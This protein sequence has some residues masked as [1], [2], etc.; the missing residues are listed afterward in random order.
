METNSIVTKV[1]RGQL[2]AIPHWFT[3][4]NEGDYVKVVKFEDD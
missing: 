3:E 2:I 1:F 4:F